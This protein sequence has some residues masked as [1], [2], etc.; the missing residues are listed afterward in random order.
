MLYLRGLGPQ[1]V[2]TH[3]RTYA[4]TQWVAQSGRGVC[5]QIMLPWRPG[6]RERE[7]GRGRGRRQQQAVRIGRGALALH[8]LASHHDSKGPDQAHQSIIMPTV[9]EIEDESYR[10]FNNE[11]DDDEWD[12]ESELVRGGGEKGMMGIVSD[13]PWRLEG[14][15]IHWASSHASPTTRATKRWPSAA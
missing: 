14:S 13:E 6:W 2:R 7:R 9:E 11:K 3:A 1:C 5:R 10:P 8:I 15:L 12:D 4:R